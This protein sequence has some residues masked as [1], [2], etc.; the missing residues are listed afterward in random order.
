MKL[1]YENNPNQNPIKDSYFNNSRIN[2]SKKYD[3]DSNGENYM[4]DNLRSKVDLREN[5]RNVND[6][7]NGSMNSSSNNYLVEFNEGGNNPKTKSIVRTSNTV[8]IEYKNYENNRDKKNKV[9]EDK[10]IALKATPKKERNNRFEDEYDSND[11]REPNDSLRINNENISNHNSIEDSY[12]S[13]ETRNDKIELENGFVYEGG[14]KNGF[15][16]GKGKYYDSKNPKIYYDGDW[17]KNLKSGYGKEAF[18]DGSIYEGQFKNGKQNGKGKLVLSDG[19]KFEGDFKDG[20]IKG[21]GKFYYSEESYYSGEWDNN[22]FNG[23]GCLCGREKKFIGFFVN[24][25]KN[26]LG[27]V[28]FYETNSFLLGRWKDN[29]GLNFFINGQEEKGIEVFT[30]EDGG[31]KRVLSPEVYEKNDDFIALREFFYANIKNSR[32]RDEKMRINVDF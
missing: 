1:I 13:T 29:K 17:K 21:E 31:T 12:N 16:E 2:K 23:Y 25:K 3:E 8:D 9:S 10:K 32:Y 11:N 6:Y 20:N 22:F 30:A 26:G 28:Y 4:R 14:I 7:N 15:F 5:N 27:F 18:K 19:K 24:N